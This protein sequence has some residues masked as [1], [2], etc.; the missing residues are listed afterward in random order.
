MMSDNIRTL[1]IHAGESTGSGT[2]SVALPLEMANSYLVDANT[3]FSVEDVGNNPPYIY[4]RSRNPTVNQLEVRLAALE[5]AERA[6]CFSSGMAAITGLFTH[7]LGTGD[8]LVMSNVAY[9]GAVEYTLDLLPQMG[10]AVTHVDTSDLKA[11]HNAIR[12]ATK[13]IHIETPCNPILQLTDIA[14]VARLAHAA[15]AQ[16]SVDSTFA[17]PVAT[18]PLSLGADFVIHSLTKYLGGHGD[19][20]GGVL[21]GRSNDIESVRQRV[22]VH[23]GGVLSPF[24]AWLIAR[25]L[26]TVPLRM[27]AHSEGAHQVARLLQD[28]PSVTKVVF[29]GLPSHP[30]YALAQHQMQ[31]PS[32]MISF[33]TKDGRR[34]AR[35]LAERLRLITYAVSLGDVRSLIFYIDTEAIMQSTFHLEGSALDRYKSFAGE[36]I[37]RLSVGLEA[38]ADLCHDLEQALR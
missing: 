10:V 27:Q 36:G 28:H 17:T 34:M 30:Q 26:A 35:Q 15:G 31:I 1:A 24:N 12:P 38:P 13:L 16:L 25:G 9:A 11:I 21:A 2:R 14:A 8:H 18:R 7:L 29:P 20:L 5:G 4:S 22:G 33:Q 3:D 19:A 23:V 6:L 32:G 37:F